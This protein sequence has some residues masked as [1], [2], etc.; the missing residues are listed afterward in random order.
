MIQ[1]LAARYPK[2][3]A[4]FLL[5]LFY[6]SVLT[7][8]YAASHAAF[9]SRYGY[10]GL[11]DTKSRAPFLPHRAPVR[12]LESRTRPVVKPLAAPAKASIGGPGQPE[13]AS[14]KSVGTDNMVNLFTG[15]FNYNIPLLD[16]G[17]YP[18]NIFY[19]GGI[20][21]EQEASWVGLGWNINPGNVNR[22]V[23]GVPDDFDGSDMLVQRQ[24]MKPNITWGA[25]LGGDLEL[26]GYKSM[27]K[28]LALS[29]GASLGV[30]F[31]NYLGP[32]LDLGIKGGTGITVATK[33][34]SD[35]NA[36]DSS[37]IS[38]S[39]KV[40][41]NLGLNAGSRTGVTLSP[42]V[43]FTAI[44][45]R[46]NQSAAFGLS[47]ATS[48]NS[49]YGLKELQLSEQMSFS[50]SQEKKEHDKPKYYSGSGSTSSGIAISFTRPSYIPSLRMRVTN[51]A[52]SGHYQIGTGFAGGYASAEVEVYKQTAQVSA[53]D[54]VQYKPMV[55]YMYYQNAQNNPAAVMDFTRFNDKEVTPRTPVISVPQYTYDVF[56][57]QGEGTGG[58]IRAYRNDLGYV[59]DNY[60]SSKE[61]SLGIGV[62][63]GILSHF[64]ANV[65][66]IKTPTTIG[67]WNAGNKL[68]TTLGF[69]SNSGLNEH[70]YFRSPGETSVLQPGQFDRLGGTDLVRFKLGG[71]GNSPTIEPLL[72]Q[73]N[74]AG[75]S[76]STVN[77]TSVAAPSARMKRSQVISF[78]TADEASR[79][80]LDRQI[81]SYDAYTLLN[82]S[83]N[84]QYTTIDRVSEY[85]K[86][87]HISQINVTEPNGKRYIYGLPVYNIIQKDFTFSVDANAD[88]DNDKVAITGANYMSTGSPLVA[89]GS[90][91]D[92]YVQVSET[93]AYA[94]S[95][96]LSGLLSSDYTDLTG[97][98]ITD[99]DPG[100]AIK[101]NY[102]RVRANGDW[103]VHKWR[104]PLSNDHMANFNDGN[105]S[106]TKDNKGIVS[107]GERES[108]Y[109]H[110][111]E[112]KTMIAV[113][114]LANRNDGKNAVDS[115]GLI[116]YTDT[117]MKCLK[118]IDLY[119][120]ADMKKN[121]M[122]AKPVKT[123][124]FAYSYTLCNKA[125]GSTSGNGKLTL[126][127]IYFTFNGQSRVNKNKYVF[128]YTN[129]DSTATADNPAYEMNS[130]DRWGS[131]KPRSVNPS[132][133]KN[134]DYPYCVQDA[135]LKNTI[136]RN[137]GAWSLKR[138][139]LPS[140][141]QIEVTYES[142][143]YA[144][145][146][147]RR[148]ADMMQLAGLGYDST[149]ITSNLYNINSYLLNENNYLFVKV[150][151][152]CT[153][154]TDVYNYYLQG[155]SQLAVKYLVNM[156]KGTEYL[157]SYAIFDT[158]STSY[159]VL[160]SNHNIIWIKMNMVDG[161]SPLTLTALEYLREQLPGQAFPGYD[162]SDAA[163]IR[164]VGEMLAGMFNGIKN[165][166]TDP[167]T[168]F[169]SDGKARSVNL[170][171]SF[172]RLNDPDGFKYGGGHRVK[173]VR[174][175]DNWKAM[176]G[177][178]TS[179]YG[180]DY[181]YTTTESFNG[182]Q[183]TISSGVASY[184]PTIGGEEN[185]FQSIVQV[186]NRL[187]LGPTSYGSVEMPV[188]DAFFPAPCVGYSK[189]TVRSIK[190]LVTDT[191]LK[192]RSGIGKQ[193]TEFYT[194]KDFPVYYSNTTL[195]PLTDLQSHTASVNL[196]L[197]KYAYDYRALSQGFLVATND[198]HGKM[199]SQSSY[200]E[201]DE[202]TRINYTENFYRNTG[203]KGMSEQFNFVSPSQGGVI[204][205]GNM[206][207]DVDLMTDTREFTV[208]SSSWEIQAQVDQFSMIPPVW[209]PFIWPVKGNSENTYRA[210]TTTK[211]VNYHAVLDSVVVI[212][213][214]SQVSTKN[215]VFDAETGNVIVNKT[216]NEFNLPIYSTNYPAYWAYSGMGPAYKNTDAL[217]TAVFDDGKINSGFDQSVFES[218]DELYLYPNQAW[219]KPNCLNTSA[220]VSKLWVYD[221]TK[222]TSPLTT[223]TRTL[224][225]LDSAG[226]LFTGSN[227]SFRIVRS[228]K[229]NV[230][231]ASVASVVS[232]ASPVVTTNGI[233]KLYIDNT[234]KVVNATAAEFQEKWQIDNAMLNKY[235]LVFNPSTCVSSEVTDCNGYYEK[236]INP[237]VKGLVGNFR[238]W[239]SK[240]FYD[241]RT[242]TN[243][244]ST[245]IIQQNGFV[246]NFKPYWNFNTANNLVP[247]LASTQWVW[248]SQLSKV[249]AKGM[250]L[251]TFNALNI[252][253]AAQYG[254][255]KSMP[256]SIT[257]NARYNE[258]RTR[259]L[260]T[261]LILKE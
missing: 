164:Q 157:T 86:G 148:A 129:A 120:K 42:G 125:P 179:V 67:A 217:Y 181:C 229:R 44:A 160:P 53:E 131:Y 9:P 101:F 78:L 93:P 171:Q 207:I 225:F 37:A 52:W 124:H 168:S 22:N 212:D 27:P 87:H 114:T 132:G 91:V 241:Y 220:Y 2:T 72:E 234:S 183:R 214:G 200:A 111:I 158:V 247:D 74:T 113:F 172:V 199:K 254:Y 208:K 185:P 162:V 147:N 174:L 19:D 96:L 169:M 227:V 106:E 115:F 166:F 46:L 231:D 187:P 226:N 228:G 12:G 203:T 117:S 4:T 216:N 245:T 176:T 104:T 189:V 139:L 69:G 190:N 173:S 64:G 95:F 198:M 215:M 177:Q 54:Q 259:G 41:V 62:D 239:R 193:V 56:S 26:C 170:S 75:N 224:V 213:K 141:G 82:S 122:A 194:A 88:K 252:Y 94:H 76:Y 149:H 221:T 197:Y 63:I 261:T 13:M 5:T 205:P 61:S 51:S 156:P 191:T 15:D 83:N 48:Y 47:A 3:I 60:T 23:R 81:K 80:G 250:E 186:A 121:G 92:G 99:D 258:P 105:R 38:G 182:V 161:L 40:G 90:S 138:V 97:D 235:S 70:V 155:L 102:T 201:N 133:M 211:V 21:T 11:P 210:V 85:R 14:F 50:W 128:S 248:N 150:P 255:S 16:V 142:D 146:Q 35:K 253:T 30:S 107:Y 126:D 1:L 55:G 232:M 8:L 206:G 110:S 243:P 260:K 238:P 25:R 123:V 244:A 175:R 154:K 251:E 236:H 10:Y 45:S 28:W 49:R 237:Y 256:L 33:S 17:G 112:S 195:D 222:N 159:G 18:V 29:V 219:G 192:S 202:N 65:N 127:S 140:G 36:S 134:S 145:V 230:L 39:L 57:I 79:I 119:S 167:L 223:A 246:A 7:P 218:G 32:A 68:T 184:E 209:I 58:S 242:E 31:N 180:Q 43:S 144:Y 165:A 135:S 77:L 66:L 163:G 153:S 240:V 109:L 24:T 108:W 233:S 98:G 89:R 196:F 151:Q 249:N 84:L 130:T 59:R 188:M 143:D 178:Y 257:N 204:S 103:A 116:D 34:L 137:A 118:Q 20:G 6:A 136:D 152:A 100:E 73:F 71:H